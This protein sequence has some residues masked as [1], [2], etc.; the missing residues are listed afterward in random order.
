MK[1]P[2]VCLLAI[3]LTAD[4]LPAAELWVGG[5]TVDI[6]PDQPVGLD[7]FRGMRISKKP[8]TPIT[9]T[10][11]AL[12]SREGKKPLDAAIMVSC[13]II[14]IR[15]GIQDKVRDKVK[16]RLPGFDLTKIFLNATHTHSAPVTEDGKYALPETGVMKPSAYAE[17]MTGKIADAIVESWQNRRPGKAGWGQGQAVIAQ[18]RRAVYADG[19][20]KMYGATND[21]KFRGIEGYEDHNLDMLFFWDQQDRLIA[22][23]INLPCPS[24]EVGGNAVH[25]DFWHPVRLTLRERHGQHLWVLPWTGA[26]GDVVSRLMYGK[27][28][29][30]RMRKL[31]GDSSRVDELARRIVRAWEDVY[32]CARK[33]IRGDVVLRHSVK[34]LELP[35]RKV[36]EAEAAEAR[37]EAAKFAKDPAQRWNYRWNQGVVKRYEEQQAGSEEPFKME[38]HVLRLGDTV[39]CTNPF[40]LYTDYGVQMKA[41]SP[42]VQTFVIQLATASGGYLASERAVRGGG[43]GAVIQSNRIGPEG[44]Q[45]L[46]NRTVEAINELWNK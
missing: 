12:E 37:K 8:A 25:A 11:L 45:V 20:A 31:R 42:A 23:A 41:R 40:E 19:T 28:A 17:F 27:A 24:Q 16:A 3:C 2:V 26:G 9:A 14:A 21:P 43:Y 38:L 10:A 22:T 5:A 39:I 46:V 30:D 33:D 18:N 32:D 34:E 44:G 7:G 4:C 29:D 13:D 35:W 36:T 6:T 15:P 1:T